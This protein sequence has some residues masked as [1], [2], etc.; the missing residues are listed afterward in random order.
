MRIQA[1]IYYQVD[2][3][4]FQ[5]A[6]ITRAGADDPQ[7]TRLFMPVKT[8]DNFL[9]AWKKVAEQAAATNIPV[10]TVCLFLHSSKSDDGGDGFEFA[11]LSG[12]SGTLTRDDMSVL[13]QLPWIDSAQ[14]RLEIFGCNTGLRGDRGWC[15]AE[16]IAQTQGVPCRGETGY[17]YFSKVLDHYEPKTP[18][19]TNVYLHAYLRGR[20]A[21]LGI[22]NGT[23]M[24]TRAFD[25]YI[26]KSVGIGCLNLLPDVKVV[27][28]L[29]NDVPSE[30]GGPDPKLVEDG[31]IGPKTI[32][33]IKK[34][35]NL[36]LGFQDGVVEPGKVTLV[37]LLEFKT[38]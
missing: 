36:Q 34:F 9:A 3:E 20:N 24:P 7:I 11:P 37:K 31:L 33:A 19:D 21:T 28:Q 35:Q 8:K 22:G 18:E 30:K 29:L 25:P 4:A 2:D 10:E 16:H 6:A 23:R 26:K 12:E 27:Q 14:I 13:E 17:A 32:N 5:R 15:P 1:Y 38:F